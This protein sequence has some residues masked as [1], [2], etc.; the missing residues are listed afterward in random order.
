MNIFQT[1]RIVTGNRAPWSSHIAV[2][3]RLRA[4]TPVRIEFGAHFAA[5]AEL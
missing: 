2:I 3:P 4:M 5:A 1:W